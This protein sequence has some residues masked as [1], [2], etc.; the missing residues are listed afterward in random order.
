MDLAPLV[1]PRDTAPVLNVFMVR[2]ST[3]HPVIYADLEGS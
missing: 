3:G 1:P 2:G